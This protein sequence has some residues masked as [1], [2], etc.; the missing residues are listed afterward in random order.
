MKPFA[1]ATDI[2]QGNKTAT[3]NHVVTVIMMLTKTLTQLLTSIQFHLS[4]VKELLCS[5]Y[6]RFRG[7]FEILGLLIPQGVVLTAQSAAKD[8]HFNSDIYVR[9]AV[10]DPM[11]GYR[12]L[13]L[14]DLSPDA[15]E[16]LKNKVFGKLM[17]Y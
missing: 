1:E 3:I 6:E 15:K 7:V 16:A 17:K 10:L 5:L 2:V 12:W 9:S 8:L 11:H 13:D 4:V 14:C